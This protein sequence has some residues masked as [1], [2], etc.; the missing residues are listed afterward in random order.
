MCGGKRSEN[1]IRRSKATYLLF[2]VLVAYEVF[3]FVLAATHFQPPPIAGAL[4]MYQKE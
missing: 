2:F 4:W 3:F 1:T